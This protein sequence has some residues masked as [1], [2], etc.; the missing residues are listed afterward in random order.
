MIKFHTMMQ[1]AEEIDQ[2]DLNI[3]TI[4]EAY[5]SLH[6]DLRDLRFAITKNE[7]DEVP[8]LLLQISAT[9]L[10]AKE[11]LYETHVSM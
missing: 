1:L 4:E 3:Q 6:E 2:L 7:L 10:K 9:S 5:N 8:D 11:L